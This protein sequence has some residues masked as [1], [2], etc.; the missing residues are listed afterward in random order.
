MLRVCSFCGNPLVTALVLAQAA[1][2]IGQCLATYAAEYAGRAGTTHCKGSTTLSGSSTTY[3][4]KY[5]S[6]F[7]P[8]P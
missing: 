5:L 2:T 8:A 1:A 3:S 7:D 6:L 4:S